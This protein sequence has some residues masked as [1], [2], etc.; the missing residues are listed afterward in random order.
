MAPT[1]GFGDRF[2]KFRH[3]YD[4]LAVGGLSGPISNLDLDVARLV[5][6]KI[7][8]GRNSAFDDNN[9]IYH[10]QWAANIPCFEN[11]RYIG[12]GKLKP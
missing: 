1:A 9:A 11:H 12:P 8:G 6:R 3:D 2:K 7:L 10:R 5:G 4:N